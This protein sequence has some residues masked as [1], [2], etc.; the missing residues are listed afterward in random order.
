MCVLVV[1][2]AVVA[3]CGAA[4]PAGPFPPRPQDIAVDR[5]EPC[6]LLTPELVAELQIDDLDEP[7]ENVVSGARS[8]NCEGGSWEGGMDYIVQL[9]D[10]DATAAIGTGSLDQ[11]AGYGAI[12]EEQDGRYPMCILVVD[13][14]PDRAIRVQV[15]THRTVEGRPQAMA[16]VCRQAAEFTARIVGTARGLSR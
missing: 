12:R 15:G 4:E 10:L 14:R 3:G 8:R 1:A 6:D 13:A 2:G 16:D 9:I 5:I 11:V 7:S